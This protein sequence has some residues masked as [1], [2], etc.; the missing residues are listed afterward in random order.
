M[1]EGITAAQ[2]I[3]LVIIYALA[4]LMIIF[5]VMAV[6]NQ[7]HTGYT[8]CVQH[9]CDTKGNDF[10]Q[11]PRELQNCC[12]GAGGQLGSNGNNYDCMFQ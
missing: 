2:R 5:S 11:K 4:V 10:C 1:M 7:G 6:G 9:K 12:A 3:L 8:T